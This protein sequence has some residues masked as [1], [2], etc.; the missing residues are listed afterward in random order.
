MTTSRFPHLVD[1][2]SE[3]EEY[4]FFY[5]SKAGVVMLVTGVKSGEY[6][7]DDGTLHLVARALEPVDGIT[8]FTVNQSYLVD[9]T[10]STCSVCEQG[11]KNK[12]TSEDAVWPMYGCRLHGIWQK[13]TEPLTRK[14]M[15][16]HGLEFTDVAIPPGMNI[17]MDSQGEP[18]LFIDNT[19]RLG[20]DYDDS[21][22]DLL[23]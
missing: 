22:E 7:G 3:D 9:P 18:Y 1:D 17:R 20:E 14:F 11:A 12:W 21:D 19:R 6:I 8:T 16:S 5:T 10:D 13:C 2:F 23:Y 4:T 15:M